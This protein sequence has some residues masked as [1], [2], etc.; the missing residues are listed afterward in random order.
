MAAILHQ[1][2]GGIDHGPVRRALQAGFDRSLYRRC[3]LLIAASAALGDELVTDHDLPRGRVVVIP[4]GS[5]VASPPPTVPELR[6]GRNIAVL[7]V[8]NWVERKGTLELLD[9]FARLPPDLATLHLAGRHDV[10]PR[11][12][13]RVRVRLRAP[14]L[15]ARVVDHGAVSREQ[16]ARLYAGADAFVL[17]SYREPYGTVYGEALAAGLPCLGWRCGNLPNLVADGREGVILDPGDIAGLSAALHRLATDE[18][19]REQLTRA[20][21]ARGARLPTWND[22]AAQFFGALARL[23]DDA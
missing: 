9:A 5:D 13:A 14:D 2:P 8:G 12:A 22:T 17:P 6:L 3:R 16:V 10:Q 19:W 18:S 21:R 11:Y 7:S 1:P 23:V 20:A 15:V 4:P